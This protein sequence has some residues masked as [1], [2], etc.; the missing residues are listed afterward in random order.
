MDQIFLPR[1]PP[2][3]EAQRAHHRS[4]ATIDP[5]ATPGAAAPGTPSSWPA[6]RRRSS[7]ARLAA[8]SR[9]VFRTH[10]L[11]VRPRGRPHHRRA[12]AGPCEEPAVRQRADQPALCG[13]RRRGRP[14]R[15]QRRCAGGRGRTPGPAAGRGAPGTAPR[16]AP[17]RDWPRQDLYVTFRKEHPA[18]RRGQHAGHPAQAAR[19]G[20]QGHQ[21]RAAA[22]S[23]P[24]STASSRCM[25][26][27]CTAMARRP[28]PSATSR[29]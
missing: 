28:C 21:E 14:G 2:R 3:T 8:C 24:P 16:A 25:P 7:T 18:R 15:S 6:R 27:T 23:T 17:P 4:C 22:T 26:T 12:A 5:T 13:V 1:P 20:A 11:P 9:D 10:A 29:R 19:D